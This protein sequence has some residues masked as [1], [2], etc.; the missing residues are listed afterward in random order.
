METQTDIHRAGGRTPVLQMGK[1]ILLI[2]SVLLMS[3]ANSSLT[4]YTGHVDQEH[5]I[6]P[7][8]QHSLEYTKDG[9][10][11]YWNDDSTGKSGYVKPLYASHEFKGPCR[12]FELAYYYPTKNPTYHY[13]IACRNKEAFWQ[14]K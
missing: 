1:L 7:S 6:M 14:V 13:G 9:A 4:M 11:T 2:S 3:C 12:H 10:V 8:F 5:L